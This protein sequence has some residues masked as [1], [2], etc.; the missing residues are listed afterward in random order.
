MK[1]CRFVFVIIF[2]LFIASNVFSQNRTVK[3]A[4]EAFNIGE[5]KLA[6][7]LYEKSY[8]K[9]TVKEL[10]NEVAFKLGEC[11]RIMMEE[12][13][14]VKWYRKAVRGNINNPLAYLYYAN[15]L[16]IYQK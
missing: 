10:K 7:E 2:S 8:E 15:A 11:G 4:D 3:K 16:K 14:A 1:Y 13:K 5:Y 9:L 6:Y 12:R